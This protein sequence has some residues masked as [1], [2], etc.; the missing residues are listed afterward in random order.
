[1][2]IFL[3]TAKIEEIE[4]ALASNC[5]DGVTTNPTL[6]GKAG[7]DFE[8]TIVKIAKLVE[9]KGKQWVVNA[10][11]TDTS[12]GDAMVKQ[13]MSLAK[14]HRNVV[15][16]IPMTMPGMKAVSVLSEKGIRTN[17][18]LCFSPTQALLAAKAG[19]TYVSPFI[20]RFDDIAEEGVLLI[21][22][23][24]RIYD[25]FGFKTKI[26]A[27]SIRSPLHVA[28]VAEMGADVCTMPFDVFE[29]IF[30][31]PL[32]DAGLKRFAEDWKDFV[33]KEKR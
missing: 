25:N 20:G 29:K 28:Q 17:V 7:G 5:I 13:G 33:A 3:D 23:I 8:Q 12:T 6:V 31:H 4:K 19:A 11:V 21:A 15:V 26:L 30:K 32:T 14:L 24:R 9:A 2:E 1:M 16:K 10:E 22:K 18:T 27:A